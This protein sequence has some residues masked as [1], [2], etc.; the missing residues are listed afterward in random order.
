MSDRIVDMSSSIVILLDH[1]KQ[2]QMYEVYMTPPNIFPFF[3][4]VSEIIPIFAPALP[5]CFRESG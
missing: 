5:E 3:F 4:F 1:S 2:L